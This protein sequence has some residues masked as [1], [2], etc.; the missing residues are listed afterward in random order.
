MRMEQTIAE[1][2]P[3]T[4]RTHLP[5]LDG[6]RGTAIIAVLLCHYTLLMPK[7][8]LLPGLLENGWAGVDLF[9]VLSGFLITGILFDARNRQHFFRNFYLRRILRIFPLYYAFLVILCIVLLMLHPRDGTQDLWHAQPWLWTYT[10][11]IWLAHQQTW[12]AWTDMIGPLWSLSVEEQFYLVWPLVV[13]SLSQR[14]LMRV[15]VVIF[16]ARAAATVLALARGRLLHSVSTRPHASGF[17]GGGLVAG[18]AHA[19]ARWRTT[20]PQIR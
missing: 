15:C 6:L 9:F 8:R 13:F 14:H 16:V 17:A 7:D 10:V 11:N 1:P 19:L 5:G 12:T 18:L 3:S 2:I 20:G 4:T